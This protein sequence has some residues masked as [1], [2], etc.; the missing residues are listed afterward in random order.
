[1]AHE[2]QKLVNTTETEQKKN[3]VE[4]EPL[5][6]KTLDNVSGGICS[7]NICSSDALA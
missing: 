4:V 6:D 1:M 3:E 5:S 2:T 7:L